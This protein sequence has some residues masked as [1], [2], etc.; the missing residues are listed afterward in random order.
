MKEVYEW[1]EEELW[2]DEYNEVLLDN[3]ESDFSEE[4]DWIQRIKEG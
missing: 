4:T 3:L 2:D 1:W